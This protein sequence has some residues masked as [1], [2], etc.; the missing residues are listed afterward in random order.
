MVIELLKEPTE[1]TPADD[2]RQSRRHTVTLPATLTATDGTDRR[3]EV[4]VRDISLHGAGL[5]SDVPT[6]V[7]GEWH[8]DVG[9]G[10]LKLHARVRIVN[11]RIRRD[12]SWQMGA[13][14]CQG[15]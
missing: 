12:G 10:L 2:R 5:R 7:G 13:T 1:P 15:A 8:L 9:A 14:F 4:R 3:L 6:E 11:S